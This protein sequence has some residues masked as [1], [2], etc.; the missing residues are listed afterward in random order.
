MSLCPAADT[1]TRRPRDE[2]VR[3]RT[4]LAYSSEGSGAARQTCP[5]LTYWTAVTGRSKPVGA[6]TLLLGRSLR[7][8]V[9]RLPPSSRVGRL[10]LGGGAQPRFGESDV[11]MIFDGPP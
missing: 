6:Q 3:T 1:F 7:Q 11:R 8:E 2:L 9:G 10:C 4:L 5:E